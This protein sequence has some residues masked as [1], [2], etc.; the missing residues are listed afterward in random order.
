VPLLAV[1]ILVAIVAFLLLR[2]GNG[3]EAATI[4]ATIDPAGAGHVVPPHFLGVSAEYPDVVPAIGSDAT[5]GGTDEAFARL[6]DNLSEAAG[7]APTLRIGG[8]TQDIAWWN[9]GGAKPPPGTRVE[10][11]PAFVSAL[12]KFQQRTKV[13]LVLGLNMGSS[14]PAIATA[15][16]RAARQ[17][18]GA[19]I[20]A[21]ELGN[22]PFAYTQDRPGLGAARPPGWSF[23]DYRQEITR[24]TGALAAA[25]AGK[26]LVLPVPCCTAGWGGMTPALLHAS[27]IA[28]AALAYHAYPFCTAQPQPAAAILAAQ[29][30]QQPLGGLRSAL[31]SAGG[32]PVW[33]TETGANSCSGDPRFSVAL[34]APGWLLS[35]AAEGARQADFH[36]I[37]S[38]P[39]QIRFASGRFAASVSP[40]YYG[41]LMFE[42]AVGGRGARVLD[43]RAVQSSSDSPDLKIWA[44][45]DRRGFVRVLVTNSGAT[46]SGNVELRVSGRQ[47]AGRLERLLGQ[48]LDSDQATIGGQAVAEDSA[49]GRLEGRPSTEAVRA[50]ELGSY[51][52]EVPA[53]SAALLTIPPR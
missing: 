28:P 13:P 36:Q 21:F 16:A 47:S 26:P 45:S 35:L 17:R 44:T 20:T 8:G 41:M 53:A 39:F 7:S 29:A 10:I 24:F 31:D 12:K 37:S 51:R 18:L 38:S 5:S 52:F 2:A 27:R 9:P 34:W 40:L 25:G 4:S 49:T 46:R 50:D 30:A 15:W 23:S 14:D 22:E 48:G 6:I 33:V 19:S 1:A 3:T 43:A 11:T 42:R 32:L